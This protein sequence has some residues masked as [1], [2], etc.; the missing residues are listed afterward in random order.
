M[1][2]IMILGGD[3]TSD[4]FGSALAGKILEKCP[5]VTLFGVGGPLMNDAG[6]RLLYDISEQV[7]LGIFMS[8]RGSPVAKRM[9]KLVVD[10]MEREEPTLVL[11]IGLPIFGYKLLE[12][13]RAK[14][15]PVLYYYTPLSR[16]LG[17]V[18]VS[19]FPKVVDKVASISRFETAKCEE[20]GVDCEFVGH[21]LMDLADFLSTPGEARTKLGIESDETKVVAVLPGARKIEVK[22]VLPNI[23]KAL[24]IVTRQ[25]DDDDVEVIVSMAPSI[26]SSLVDEIVK[27]CTAKNVRLERD[28]YNVLRA[29]DLAVTSIGTSS[30]EASLLGVPSVA[31]YRVPQSTYLVDKILDRKPTMTITNNILRKNVIPEFVQRDVSPSKMAETLELLLFDANARQS[32]LDEFTN[33]GY[34]LGE[35]GSVDRAA[36]LVVEMARCSRD[37]ST[38]R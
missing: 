24:D 2:K 38:S 28:I 10:A 23:L 12:I 13:A 22:S 15:I 4:R 7:S 17:S 14:G 18:R 19:D 1:K 5:Y 31:V 21:P 29:A 8:M 3:N 16:G 36:N 11:Q 20:V 34:E 6:V 25:H 26:R 30:L 33:L 37:E 32:M 27:G 9:M 35:P